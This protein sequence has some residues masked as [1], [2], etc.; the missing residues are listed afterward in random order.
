MQSSE[1][2]K[3]TIGEDFTLGFLSDLRVNLNACNHD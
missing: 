3:G 1:E 2:G